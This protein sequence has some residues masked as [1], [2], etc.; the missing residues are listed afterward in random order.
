MPV[1]EYVCRACGKRFSESK[2]IAAYDPKKVK[3]P[4][5]KS[6]RVDRVWSTVQVSTSKKS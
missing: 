4:K 3:C 1:Y 5:C 6:K 2:S